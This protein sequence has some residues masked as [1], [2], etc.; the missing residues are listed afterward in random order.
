LFTTILFDMDGTLVPMDMNT[1]TNAYMQ[2]VEDKFARATD[3]KKLVRD[4]FYG[5]MKMVSDLDP[6]RTNR[7]VFW[8]HFS[9]QVGMP[10]EVLEPLFLE[11]YTSEFTRLKESLPGGNPLARPLMEK[12]FQAGCRVAIATNPLFPSCAIMERLSWVGVRDFPYNL[13]TTY[14]NM[15][16]CKPHIEYYKEVIDLLGVSPRECLMVGNDVE[17]DL[18][19]RKLGIRVFLVEDWLLNARNLPVEADYRGSFQDLV[20]F[21]DQ[22]IISPFGTR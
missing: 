16:F 10:E 22:V 4:I 9:P 1:F 20:E 15:H 21:V 14:E 12:L 6:S 8:E 13:V 5:T 17:E 7:Q 3:T 11:F 19:A 18:A 2:A